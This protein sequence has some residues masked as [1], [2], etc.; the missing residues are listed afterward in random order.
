MATR[1]PRD[2]NC[3]IVPGPGGGGAGAQGA[4]NSRYPSRSCVGWACLSCALTTWSAVGTRGCCTEVSI[5][6]CRTRSHPCEDR[7][8]GRQARRSRECRG[9]AY[10]QALAATL[11][12][13]SVPR[14]QCYIRPRV[15]GPGDDANDAGVV[16]V[17][18]IK[19]NYKVHQCHLSCFSIFRV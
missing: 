17:S 11:Q 4:L 8:G 1:P 9:S 13:A 15:A 5:V 10:P 7:L 16:L 12:L 2:P 6:S 19:K 18:F 3:K 14:M